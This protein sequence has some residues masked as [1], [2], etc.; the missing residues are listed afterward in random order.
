VQGHE[1][2]ADDERVLDDA[3]REGPT[4][5]STIWLAARAAPADDGE[6]RECARED[7]SGRGHRGAGDADGPADTA[8]RNGI[9]CASSLILVMTRML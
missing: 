8:S 4:P 5:T 1:H 9:R 2:G 3:D 7:Q 6:H